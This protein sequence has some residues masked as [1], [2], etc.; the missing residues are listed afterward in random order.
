ME[1][2]IA[3]DPPSLEEGFSGLKS[4]RWPSDI[5]PAIDEKLAAQGGE[6]YKV[7][8]QECHRPPVSTKAFFDFNNK[9]WWTR[10][11]VGEPV[12]KIENI[13]IEHIGTD[14]AQAADMMSRTVAIP[15]ESRYRQERFR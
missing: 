4:P 10:N 12:L 7:H 6:L 8:C 14:P 2:M 1:Q 15:A 11:E 9:D 13:P 3:G 5:L